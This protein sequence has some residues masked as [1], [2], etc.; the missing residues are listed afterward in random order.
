[1]TK[2]GEIELERQFVQFSDG[3][4]GLHVEAYLQVMQGLNRGM[5]WDELLGYRWVVVLGE[6]GTGK[7]TEFRQR[8]SI[9]RSLGKPAFFMDIT[10]LAKHG[11]KIAVE[12]ATPGELEAWREG[13]AE[14][15]FFLDSVDEAELR[16]QS[17]GD[18]LRQLDAYMGDARG[19]ARL[20]ASC[21]VSDWGT[22]SGHSDMANYIRN[23]GGHPEELQ[24][25]QLM[26]LDDN[27][28]KRLAQHYGCSD[29]QGL[30]DAV[31]KA[32]AQP[33]I[34]RPLDVEWMVDY[35]NDHNEVGTLTELVERSVDKRLDERRPNSCLRSRLAKQKARDGLE[36]L[37]GLAVL[38]GRWSFLVPG[39]ESRGL[40]GDDTIDPRQALEDWSDDEIRELLTRASSTNP[41][42][43]GSAFTIEP[44]RST[45][46]P[47]G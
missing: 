42:T 31:R 33:F 25:V 23:V 47:S 27:R 35:W 41:P 21:R 4:T 40:G 39:E 6:A 22:A 5:G 36:R 44:F 32:S 11:P 34:A 10:R 26:P 38:S 43:A 2:K 45:S 46:P 17:L 30:V 7:S 18:A 14:A 9:L 3:P 28:V 13:E 12:Q 19:R 20:L 1:M 15:V 16:Q 37:A 29:P 24:I 8:P